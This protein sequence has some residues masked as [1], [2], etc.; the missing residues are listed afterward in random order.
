MVYDDDETVMRV[1]RLVEESTGLP[2][3][4]KRGKPCP[5]VRVESLVI[6]EP[7]TSADRVA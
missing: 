4:C 7:D 2:C 3:P 1:Q 6:R 5:L